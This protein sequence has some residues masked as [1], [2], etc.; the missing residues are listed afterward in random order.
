METLETLKRRMDTAEDIRDLVRTLKALAAVS[1]R[2]YERSVSALTDYDRTIELG[3]R[4]VLRRAPPPPRPRRP[5][6]PGRTGALVLGSDQGLCGTFNE[7]VVGRVISDLD[8]GVMPAGRVRVYAVGARAGSQ[9]SEA[10]LQPEGAT[11]LPLSTGLLP[12]LV[13]DLLLLVN[14]WLAD[15]DLDGVVLYYNRLAGGSV[16]RPHR[17]VLLP[18][19]PERL[20][21]LSREPWPT[22]MLPLHTVD[23]PE[24]LSALIRQYLF[25]KLHRALTFSLAAEH[26]SRL[27]AM[28]AAE[29]NIDERLEELRG[30]YHS[31][32]QTAITTELLDIVS[33]A[34]AL[35][36]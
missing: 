35:S 8:A 11:V 18:I 3:L 24:L 5:R 12:S 33:G 1:V 6:Q 27:V 16:S 4:A 2:H 7:Q 15:G 21:R 31:Q 26:A 30:R 23:R 22:R 19:T 28:Q 34:E 25:V 13:Q 32:R 17:S 29:R 36:E 14:E 10:G 20:R 9:L